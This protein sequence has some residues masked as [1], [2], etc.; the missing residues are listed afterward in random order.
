MNT[1]LNFLIHEPHWVWFYL[2]LIFFSLEFILPGTFFLWFSLAAFI[3]S[4]INYLWALTLISQLIS[5]AILALLTI[6]IGRKLSKQLSREI[7]NHLNRRREM[8]IGH[9][10][11]LTNAIINNQAQLKIGDMTWPIQGPNLEAGARI[12]IAYVE[13]NTL[14]VEES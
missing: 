5:F 3:L 11:T 6:W 12:K 14:I 4:G 13:G 2:G 8:L 1:I 9:T 10:F 7:P